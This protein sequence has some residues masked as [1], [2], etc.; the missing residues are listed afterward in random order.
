M[1]AN[2]DALLH[3]NCPCM[4]Q[5]A[6]PAIICAACIWNRNSS[7][8]SKGIVVPDVAAVTIAMAAW[9]ASGCQRPIVQIGDGN[10]SVHDSDRHVSTEHGTLPSLPARRTS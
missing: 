1:A 9:C 6:C 3:L 5:F 2:A 10:F 4:K 8:V 7:T